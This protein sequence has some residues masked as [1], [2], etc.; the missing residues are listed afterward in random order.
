M[1]STSESVA[2]GQSA[3][4]LGAVSQHQTTSALDPMKAK[5]PSCQLAIPEASVHP[6]SQQLQANKKRQQLRMIKHLQLKVGAT[7][8]KNAGAPGWDRHTEVLHHKRADALFSTVRLRDPLRLRTSQA[9]W[10]LSKTPQCAG[11]RGLQSQPWVGTDLMADA[12]RSGQHMT[13]Q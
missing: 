1:S 12:S 10:L 4:R 8:Y 7:D 3:T 9:A 2:S 6:I 5:S 13:L 11:L